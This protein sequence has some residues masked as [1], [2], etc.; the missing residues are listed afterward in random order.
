[1]EKSNLLDERKEIVRLGLKMLNAGLTTGSGGN[2]SCYNR[3]EGLIA[4]TPSGVEYPDLTPEQILLMTPDGKICRENGAET[5][6]PSSEAGFHLDLYQSRPD[7]S[8]VVHTHSPYASTFAC[9]NMEIP[10]VHY[11]VAFAGK[12]VSVA[13][14]ATFGSVE[15]ARNIVETIKSDNAVLLANHGLVS[16]GT[17]LVRAFNAAEEIELVAR[18]YYQT[19]CIGKPVILSDEQMDVVMEKFKTYGSGQKK[20]S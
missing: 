6:L 12:K 13:P 5:G 2:L 3:E 10:A 1:M 18:I 8:A 7:V 4:I 9:L 16:V 19:L 20:L 11:L 17:S 14:Y 15:L